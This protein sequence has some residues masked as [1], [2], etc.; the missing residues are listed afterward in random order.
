M[1]R[2]TVIQ[3]GKGNPV[4]GPNRL[5]DNDFVDIIE[6]IPVLITR[7]QQKT[8]LMREG[9]VVEGEWERKRESKH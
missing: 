9:G 8:V 1:K 7:Q 4:L 6:F 3:V 5:S 2:Q